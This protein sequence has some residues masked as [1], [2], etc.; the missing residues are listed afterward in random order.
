MPIDV[1]VTL[2]DTIGRVHHIT[3][4]QREPGLARITIDA[5]P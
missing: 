5:T 3:A 4:N 2:I 1:N